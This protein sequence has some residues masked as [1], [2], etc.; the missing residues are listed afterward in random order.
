MITAVGPSNLSSRPSIPASAKALFVMLF[1]I[2]LY[3]AFA[4][5]KSFLKEVTSSTLIHL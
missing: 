4:F 5:L 3:S 1:L 2:T